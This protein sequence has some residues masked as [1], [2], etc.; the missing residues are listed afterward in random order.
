MLV[1]SVNGQSN[2]INKSK[3]STVSGINT[4]LSGLNT[5]IVGKNNTLD[6]DST[7]KKPK[8]DIETTIEYSAEDSIVL[9]AEDR[10]AFLFNDSK[11]KFG[12]MDL[13]ANKIDMDYNTNI[14][15]A[16]YKTDS[17]GKKIGVPLFKEGSETYEAGNISYNYKTKK[18]K[19]RDIV[20]KQ[21]DA[22]IQGKD[23]RKEP[24]NTMFVADA[25]YTTCDLREPHFCI[26]ATHIK[27]IPSKKIVSRSFNLQIDNVPTLLAFPFGIFPMP[28]RRG[29]GLIFPSY[30]ESQQRGFFLSNL[31]Y[32]LAISDYFG[33]KFVTDQYSIG[34]LGTGRYQA[35]LDYKSRYA[36]Q[37]K[38]NYQF[39]NLKNSPDNPI[40]S[41]Q[42]LQHWIKW[43]HST[44]TKGAGRFSASVNAGTA[45][46]NRNNEFNTQLR[47][48]G[49]FN[50]NINYD[51]S[52]KRTPF[53]YSIR[54]RQSQN[55]STGIMNFKLPELSVNM[56][57]VY[58][59]KN[60]PFINKSDIVK[61][62]NFGITSSFSNDV[63]NVVRNTLPSGYQSF[64]LSTSKLDRNSPTFFQDSL[65]I[66]RKLK[67]DTLNIERFFRDFGTNSR[68]VTNYSVPISTTFKLF[69]YFNFTP[70]ASYTENWYSQQYAYKNVYQDGIGSVS[71]VNFTDVDTLRSFVN[72]NLARK[73]TITT[74]IGTTTRIYGTF[75]IKAKNL[76]AIR[77]V[78]N[79]NIGYSFTPVL[80]NQFIRVAEVSTA[81]G[82]QFAYFDR[83]TGAKV[84]KNGMKDVSNITFGLT[85]TLEA[86]IRDKKDTVKV[87]YK[88]QMLIDNFAINGSYDLNKDS[89]NLS[90][91]AFT[92]R[93]KLF[94][95]FDI[96]FVSSFDPYYYDEVGVSTV[97]GRTILQRTKNY[98]WNSVDSAGDKKNNT[99][100][101]N[102]DQGLGR[103]TDVRVNVTA[104]FAPKKKKSSK[105]PN[106]YY[107]FENQFY[108]NPMAPGYVD[109]SL[110]WSFNITYTFAYS[111]YS[112]SPGNQPIT[113][114][115]SSFSPGPNALFVEKSS[116][117][118]NINISGDFTPT[119]KW[120]IA[121]VA[122]FDANTRQ[123]S[124]TTLNI[125]RDLHCWYATFSTGLY[126]AT[127]QYYLFTIGV[128]SGALSDLKIPRRS[129][130]SFRDQ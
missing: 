71:G 32:Y 49:D 92:A 126:P 59:L 82:E 20:T 46:F 73:N 106:T 44:L 5:S 65:E 7:Q 24:D 48:T 93:T 74:G 121:Y 128:K 52:I 129:N 119:A 22:V 1:T 51:N 110:P 4:S 127:F 105:I 120:K 118:N 88:K 96:N 77:H 76:E 57:R 85:N 38:F 42:L 123:M 81:L 21:G 66:A 103:F 15:N 45:S 17:T 16:S 37:G 39:S 68:W 122:G 80:D 2:K 36:F 72:G 3:S 101:W 116:F 111:K 43:N 100:M 67:P 31:G 112:A 50:S 83:F 61:K 14:V 130:N 28:K 78:I 47:Q 27:V 30:G 29:S 124:T 98:A 97:T 25:I 87:T 26:K 125:S 89:F 54:A 34:G 18:G 109:F 102:P 62:F 35:D 9:D 115:I 99:F 33:F 10:K 90:N 8:R 70:N 63:S 69:K 19:V 53:S 60:V 23:V 108:Y 104:R 64:D 40:T 91:L 107:G 11:V 58:P 86:K 79:P 55:I 84:T 12:K 114:G 41:N 13:K 56:N 94:G 75:Y 117:R 6:A 113:N 95:I